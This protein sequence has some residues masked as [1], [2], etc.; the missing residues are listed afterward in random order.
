VVFGAI[1]VWGLKSTSEKYLNIDVAITLS[2]DYHF[3]KMKIPSSVGLAIR[4]GL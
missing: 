3:F 1:N 4:H 2:P